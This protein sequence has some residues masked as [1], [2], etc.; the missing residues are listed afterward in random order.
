MALLWDNPQQW[1]SSYSWE[2]GI[3]AASTV[4][5]ARRS[6][7][8]ALQQ[9]PTLVGEQWQFQFLTSGPAAQNKTWTAPVLLPVHP[10]HRSTSEAYQDSGGEWTRKERVHLRLSDGYDLMHNGDLAIDPN[11]NFWAYEAIASSGIGTT[12]YWFHR[13]VPLRAGGNRGGGV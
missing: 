5:Q 9:I 12:A 11:G 2:G 3:A 4:S 7:Q 13:D 1:D 6:M 8:G 10:T